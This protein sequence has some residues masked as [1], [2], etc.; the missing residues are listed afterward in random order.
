MSLINC[1]VDLELNW[2]EDSILSSAGG[3]AILS[4]KD[5]ANLTKQFSEVFKRYVYWNSYET[6]PAKVIAQGKNLYEL[7]NVSFQGV[8]RLFVF[9]YAIDANRNYEA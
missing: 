3:S 4:T 2:I 9:A 5:R 1:K 8:K 7:L 6:N